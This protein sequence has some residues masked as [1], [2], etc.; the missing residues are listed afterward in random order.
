MSIGYRP[1]S[2]FVAHNGGPD[3]QRPRDWIVWHFTHIDNLP[4]IIACSRLLPDAAV[5]P[6]TDVAYD[7]VKEL[8]R[9]KAVRPDHA[10]PTSMASDHVPFYIA[11]RSPMLYIACRG[12]QGHYTGGRH[13]RSIW[14]PN[15]MTSLLP[16]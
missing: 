7:S 12:Y 6:T 15:S 2:G 5:T 1:E 4:S 10:H 8:R 14:E 9:H 11:A 16:D 13:L 3:R